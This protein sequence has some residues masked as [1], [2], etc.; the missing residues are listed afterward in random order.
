M[1]W[2]M[3]MWWIGVAIIGALAFLLDGTIGQSF[4]HKA[5]A[6][7][8][9]T[10]VEKK[11]GSRAKR[12]KQPAVAVVKKISLAKKD[13][14][15][16]IR[17]K[18]A[19]RE[20][21]RRVSTLR[22]FGS[23]KQRALVRSRIT[24]HHPVRERRRPT[25]VVRE[26]AQLPEPELAR[27][28]QSMLLADAETGQVLLAENIDKQ[29]P[30]AS[31]AKMMVG[32]LAMEDLEQG[33][34]SLQTPVVVSVRASRAHGR[35]INLRPGEVF[36]LG[37]L[38]QAMLV[39]SANDASIAVAEHIRGSVEACVAA[40]N[41]KARALGMENTRYQTVNGMPLPGGGAGDVSS[42]R[43]LA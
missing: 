29:W 36:P 2:R 25:L 14:P 37:E 19:N 11:D 16:L 6:S 28:F 41:H 7:R 38:L 24:K 43:D 39:T 3:R 9:A 12:R 42:A 5:K 33:R 10:R 22:G 34:I 35:T 30:T 20:S 23:R 1:V 27:D 32:L 31:L 13:H 40:M 17:S 15:R 4:A 21:G 26:I 8:P 18:R